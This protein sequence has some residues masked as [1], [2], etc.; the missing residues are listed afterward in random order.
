MISPVKAVTTDAGV[1]FMDTSV[2]PVQDHHPRTRHLTAVGMAS[3]GQF[4]TAVIEIY[5]S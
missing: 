5:V 1:V 3:A 4:A 2:D